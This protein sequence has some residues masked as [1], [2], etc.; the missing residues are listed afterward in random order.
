[1][2]VTPAILEFVFGAE[3]RGST[4]EERAK[5][6]S[7]IFVRSQDELA[8]YTAGATGRRL[9][10]WEALKAFGFE[11]LY[12]ASTESSA[13]LV[14]DF[15]RPAVLLQE[16]RKIL[17]LE[18][19]DLARKLKID[20]KEIQNAEK[21]SNRTP[22]RLLERIAQAL[23]L[24]ESQLVNANAQTG[25][26][27][28]AVRLRELRNSRSEFR[29]STVLTFDEAAWVISKQ[30]LLRSWLE[31]H[32]ESLSQRGFET[33]SRYGDKQYPAW[34]YGY[35]L[36][37]TSRR[38]LGLSPDR[39][40]LSLKRLVEETLGIPIVN[41]HLPAGIAG[42][43]I[44]NG[45]TR[46]I[47]VNLGG[48]NQ[49]IWVRRMTIAHELGHLLWDP[50]PRLE[51]LRV[52]LYRD[53]EEQ[54]FDLPDHVEARANAFAIE[55]LAPQAQ[56][57]ELYR[58]DSDSSRATRTIMEK[59]GISFTSAKYQIWNS[60]E[61]A[62]SIQNIRTTDI[63]PTDEWKGKE[64]FALDFFRP[65]A[66]PETRRGYFSGLVAA[67]QIKGFISPDSAAS[68]LGCRE[69]EYAQSAHLIRELYPISEP[70]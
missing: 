48:D 18:V 37:E 24:D 45:N 30:H 46:G 13:I 47:I 42:A 17:G 65:E 52:D 9:M 64:D 10:A 63:E 2:V 40:I 26:P 21:T 60:L 16:R 15:R 58:N 25:D 39:P 7:R 6:S 55:F 50:D 38:I 34:W 22:I 68:Y 28:L 69:S 62:L 43:T 3:S 19:A 11:K 70:S 20:S 1:V 44:S 51:K 14:S 61:R 23:G 31:P 59:F 5:T 67:A 66:V 35:K 27:E 56:V 57:R 36:A 53:F 49:N 54:P 4:P 29:P 8:V 33:D 12:E 32:R 41:A